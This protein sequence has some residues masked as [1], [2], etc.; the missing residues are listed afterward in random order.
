MIFPQERMESTETQGK[1]RKTNT[2]QEEVQVL[3]MFL[4]KRKV[5]GGN[6]PLSGL[7]TSAGRS[8]V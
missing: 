8:F 6:F 3:L 4:E 2:A 5:H 7:Q 1:N